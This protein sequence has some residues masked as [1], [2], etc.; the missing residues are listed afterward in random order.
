MEQLTVKQKH[1]EVEGVNLAAIPGRAI[2]IPGS[3]E[4]TQTTRKLV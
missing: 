3:T 2:N 1:E 4:Q